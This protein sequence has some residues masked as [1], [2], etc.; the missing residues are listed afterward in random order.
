MAY[1]GLTYEIIDE[2]A[3]VTL[4]RP[5][6][7]NAIDR[8]LHG[9]ILDVC[10]AIKADDGVRVAIFTGAGRGFCSGAQVGAGPSPSAEPGWQEMLD[11]EG[12]VGRQAKAVY[13][14]GKPTIAAVNGIAAGAGMSLAL[15]CDLR[16]GSDQARFK[17]V[18]IERA[19][20]PDAGMTYFLPRIVGTGYAMDLVLTS[21]TVDADEAL[22]INLLQRLVP[23]AELLDQSL[24]VARTIAAHPPL[25]AQMSKRSLQHSLD[26]DFET[27]LRYELRAIDLG[28]RAKNDAAESARAF[29]EKR[30]PR[31]TGH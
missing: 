18:F 12:W 2:V 17:T 7:L 29:L 14:I 24:A 22:R 15:A 16:I 4:N 30:Q 20:A 6:K 11:E 5:E 1:Q 27:Q 13:L 9:E 28:R 19:L 25:A 8:A 31:Y 21:R 3:V 10:A 23:H 26:H